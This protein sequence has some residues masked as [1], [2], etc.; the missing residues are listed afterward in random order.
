MTGTV[1][2]YQERKPSFEKALEEVT[3]LYYASDF[4]TEKGKVRQCKEAEKELQKMQQEYKGKEEQRKLLLLLAANAELQ[5]EWE[6]TA[7][8]YEQLLLY[9]PQY[10]EGYGKYGIFL[11]RAGQENASRRLWAAWMKNNKENDSRE[12]SRSFFLWEKMLEKNV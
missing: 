12:K 8:Y 1:L 5:E 11:F 3:R 6:R 2:M 4:N 10:E 9:D 7:V